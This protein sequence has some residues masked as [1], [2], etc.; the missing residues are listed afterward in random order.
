MNIVETVL[1]EFAKTQIQNELKENK[2]VPEKVCSQI[3]VGGR[4]QQKCH[5]ELNL[6]LFYRYSNENTQFRE[7]EKWLEGLN[8]E[9]L[10]DEW[11]SNFCK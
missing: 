1:D 7:E 9:S 10:R 5:D 6:L 8:S 4:S 3:G 2:W 11:K